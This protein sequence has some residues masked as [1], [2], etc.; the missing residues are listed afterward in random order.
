MT[1]VMVCP[2]GSCGGRKFPQASGRHGAR[3]LTGP[4]DAGCPAGRGCSKAKEEGGA[5][6]SRQQGRGDARSEVGAEG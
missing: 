4:V 1:A 2:V 6:A 3:S 5:P